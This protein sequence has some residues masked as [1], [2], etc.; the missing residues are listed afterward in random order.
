MTFNKLSL[1]F[2]GLLYVASNMRKWD[3]KEIFATRWNDDAR[4]LA[5]EAYELCEC[6]WLVVKE[7]PI[8]AFGAVPI[9]PGVWNVWCFAT[10]DFP[11]VALG[12][13]R[14]IRKKMIPGLT[15]TGA[16][17]AQCYSIEGHKQAHSWLESLGGVRESSL[18][19]YGKNGET[20]HLY[21]WRN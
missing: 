11:K 9:W 14:F 20:F 2:N 10:D 6:G 4:Q 13:T 12:V 8:C 15:R 7:K 1:D 18:M 5:L 19:N 3:H 21:V 17:R 16:R